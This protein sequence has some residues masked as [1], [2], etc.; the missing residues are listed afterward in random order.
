MVYHGLPSIFPIQ[1]SPVSDSPIGLTELSRS[2]GEKELLPH[3]LTAP[4]EKIR[5]R[6]SM[7]SKVEPFFSDLGNPRAVQEIAWH[8]RNLD[9]VYNTSRSGMIDRFL[10]M[11]LYI[12]LCACR[13]RLTVIDGMI[14][15]FI[16]WLGES[17]ICAARYCLKRLVSHRLSFWRSRFWASFVWSPEKCR[18]RHSLRRKQAGAGC[19]L[20]HLS[21][22]STSW[23]CALGVGCLFNFFL[24][25]L[26]LSPSIHHLGMFEQTFKSD[27]PCTSRHLCGRAP[28]GKQMSKDR[29]R[30]RNL[31]IQ[32]CVLR[33]AISNL[34]HCTKKTLRRLFPARKLGK[35]AKTQET[36]EEL[37]N[38]G[39]TCKRPSKCQTQN[40]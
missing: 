9:V 15:T 31:R 18:V 3:S 39:K 2:P 5:R 27:Q 33:G 19:W 38:I 10:L 25:I 6:A 29:K 17:E 1:L 30:R 11:I 35:R 40:V 14:E 24:K 13:N 16:R 32:I 34:L 20:E 23:R 22:H 21:S 36:C 28:A 12:F 7:G 37:Q 4:A 8:G 26:T